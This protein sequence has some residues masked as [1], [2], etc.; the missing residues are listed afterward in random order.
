MAAAFG[1]A[2]GLGVAAI[3]GCAEEY[4]QRGGVRAIFCGAICW[5]HVFTGK[6]KEKKLP[7]SLAFLRLSSQSPGKQRDGQE[8]DGRADKS[9]EMAFPGKVEGEPGF[10][11]G[12]AEG[13]AGGARRRGWRFKRGI[14]LVNPGRGQGG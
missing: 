5:G 14:Y 3:L 6:S 10:S 12:A 9:K 13:Q 7:E 2:P 1:L 4:R 11:A 8:E